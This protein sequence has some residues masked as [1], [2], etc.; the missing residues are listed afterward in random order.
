M[1]VVRLFE[2]LIPMTLLPV[3]FSICF[4]KY[5]TALRWAHTVLL[6]LS[7]IMAAIVGIYVLATNTSLSFQLPFAF[8]GFQCSLS[9]RYAS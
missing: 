8:P 2:F 7:G 5:S 6:C 9:T 3:I 4:K 1:V